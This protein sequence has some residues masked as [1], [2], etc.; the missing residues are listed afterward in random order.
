MPDHTA[1]PSFELTTEDGLQIIGRFDTAGSGSLERRDRPTLGPLALDQVPDGLLALKAIADCE[2]D[3][4]TAHWSSGQW[5]SGRVLGAVVTWIDD[6]TGSGEFSVDG[7]LWSS[8]DPGRCLPS[9]VAAFG[10][11]LDSISWDLGSKVGAK[12]WGARSE[13]YV[14]LGS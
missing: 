6:S 13:T 10:P 12:L 1:Q 3:R 2:S 8:S 11:L 9:D 5:E 7:W 4:S 14:L